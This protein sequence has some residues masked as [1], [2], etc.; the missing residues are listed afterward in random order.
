M[1]PPYSRRRCI[2]GGIAGRA[3]EPVPL[4]PRV[5]R[6][7]SHFQ[8]DFC[9]AQGFFRSQQHRK[10]ILCFSF[11][12]FL[13]SK[14]W[15]CVRACVK[16]ERKGMCVCTSMGHGQMDVKSVKNIINSLIPNCNKESRVP[17]GH[18][19]LWTGAN[20]SRWPMVRMLLDTCTCMVGLH[21][22]FVWV[23]RGT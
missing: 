20:S 10:C 9:L 18:S 12:F 21:G 19:C 23:K 14:R 16:R 1:H 5:D 7:Q 6:R 22:I 15:L 2:G 11:L 13:D 17:S 8:K 3:R 4:G